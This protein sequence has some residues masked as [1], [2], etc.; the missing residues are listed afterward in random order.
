MSICGKPLT[1]V[2]YGTSDPKAPIDELDIEFCSVCK[3]AYL[4]IEGYRVR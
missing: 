2:N 3:I 1:I 4:D